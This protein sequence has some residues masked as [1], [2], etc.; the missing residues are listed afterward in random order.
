VSTPTN[1]ARRV[2]YTALFGSYEALVEQPIAKAVPNV[3]FVCF[4]DVPRD[5]ASWRVVVVELPY[6]TDAVRSARSIKILGHDA[7]RHYDEWLWIDNRVI[8]RASPESILDSLLTGF[9]LAIPLHDHRLSVADEYHAVLRAGFDN[10]YRVREELAVLRRDLPS[11]LADRPLWTGLIARRPSASVD[12]WAATWMGMVLLYSRRDQLSVNYA[13]ATSHLTMNTVL[14]NNRSSRFHTWL[15]VEELPKDATTRF[16]AS[17]GFRYRV[18]DDLVDR[19]ILSAAGR[20]L[21]RQRRALLRLTSR[22]TSRTA[23]IR[24]STLG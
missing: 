19:I 2:V 10:P 17:S 4:S 5:S 23:P 14:V 8:L 1:A 22:T 24:R 7:L 21:R 3:D 13:I 6:P 16:S 20:L 15:T 9:D 18:W 11:V 12:S